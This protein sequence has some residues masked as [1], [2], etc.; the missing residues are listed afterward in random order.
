M[1]LFKYLIPKTFP[2]AVSSTALS[3]D[4]TTA[5]SRAYKNGKNSPP[6]KNTWTSLQFT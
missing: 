2:I 4:N 1:P 3:V 6:L 5:L